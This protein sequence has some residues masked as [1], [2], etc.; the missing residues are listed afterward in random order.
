MATYGE[1]QKKADIY[2]MGTG[3]LK[4]ESN[5]PTTIKKSISRG[6]G[7]MRSKTYRES[8]DRGGL[9]AAEGEGEVAES[10]KSAS[11]VEVNAGSVAAFLQVKVLVSDMPGSMQVHAFK[12]ARRIYDSLEKFSTKYM[13]YNM[14]KDFD[15]EYGP[16]W[17][18]V[19]G[20]SFGSFVTHSTGCFLYFSME[21][22]YILVFRTKV[23]R[24]PQ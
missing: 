17:H 12:S 2:D 3:N 20:S 4:P 14:K 5:Y 19:A 21:K 10:R 24:A 8:V 23:Q 22:W 15:K 1:K 7:L 13:A 6:W 9:K 16:A 18:C 11:H